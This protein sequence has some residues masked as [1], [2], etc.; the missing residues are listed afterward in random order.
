M[1]L[2]VRDSKIST[3]VLLQQ[4]QYSGYVSFVC[5]TPCIRASVLFEKLYHSFLLLIVSAH[6]KPRKNERVIV[7]YS[8]NPLLKLGAVIWSLSLNLFLYFFIEESLKALNQTC[9]A[10]IV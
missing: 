1:F 10:M 4:L 8:F 9:S 2:T 7:Q 6:Q 5:S 3:F